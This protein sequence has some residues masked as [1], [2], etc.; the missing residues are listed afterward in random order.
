MPIIATYIT[1][2]PNTPAPPK[3]TLLPHFSRIQKV[4]INASL[5]QLMDF[6]SS[7]CGHSSIL[8]AVELQYSFPSCQGDD[9]DGGDDGDE[10]EDE[11]DLETWKDA[12][13]FPPLLRDAPGLTSLRV[14]KVP[15]PNCFLELHHLTHL[16]LSRTD[17][18]SCDYLAIMKVNP[19]LEVVIFR[20]GSDWEGEAYGPDTV[21]LPR[22]RRL[23][24]YDALASQ[25]LWRCTFPPG[26][27]FS[28]VCANGYIVP[29]TDNQLNI[30]TVEKLQFVFS[31]HQGLVSRVVTGLGPNG[32]FLLGDNIHQLS[33]DI[34]EVSLR[35]LVELSITFAD[36]GSGE[37]NPSL[38]FVDMHGYLSLLLQLIFSSF[39]RLRVLI[40]QRVHGCEIILRLLCDPSIC[41]QL[42]TVILANV[43]SHTTYWPSLVEM[44]RARGQHTSTSSIYRV[45][46]GCRTEELPEQDQLAELR[47]HVSSAEI[48]P[49]NYRIEELDWLNDS[50]FRN[51]GRL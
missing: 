5:G 34:R 21:S 36:I 31:R 47:A 38:T 11:D 33:L 1:P 20:G 46:I 18:S 35:P 19:M 49:W 40:L 2:N 43:Q 13:R 7:L 44:A 32:T 27:H 51:L 14:S 39:T 12:F 42:N 22:L 10:D 24:L 25:L 48:K 15:F 45:D 50:R 37:G 9:E 8:E 28:Y 4:H 6:L 41:P 26:T 29:R 16:E 17:A 30:S 23:E 3:K